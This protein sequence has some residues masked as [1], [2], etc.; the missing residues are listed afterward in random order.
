MKLLQLNLFERN[1]IEQLNRV[2]FN[3]KECLLIGNTLHIIK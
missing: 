2:D 3:K 1:Q